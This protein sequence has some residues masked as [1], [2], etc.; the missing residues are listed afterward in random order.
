MASSLN[1]RIKHFCLKTQQQIGKFLDLRIEETGYARGYLY[2]IDPLVLMD[3]AIAKGKVYVFPDNNFKVNEEI[4]Y[5]WKTCTILSNKSDA[6]NSRHYGIL[7]AFED[8][9]YFPKLQNGDI[10]LGDVYTP[11]SNKDLIEEYLTGQLYTN[12]T[13]ST[14]IKN[15][16]KFTP[17]SFVLHDPLLFKDTYYDSSAPA[18]D[19]R[20]LRGKFVYCER[21]ICKYYPLYKKKTYTL[22][23]K[24]AKLVINKLRM[25][26]LLILKVISLTHS[27]MIIT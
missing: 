22:K 17:F 23:G 14:M 10:E 21:N 4:R 1:F 2:L 24:K 19:L 5:T 20:I 8:K 25:D 27:M 16:Q 11:L 7:K 6:D 9:V 3:D 18:I 26:I 12:Y 15:I 13:K